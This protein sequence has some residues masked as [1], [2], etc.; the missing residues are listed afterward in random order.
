MTRL[1]P[2]CTPAGRLTAPL[3]LSALA[4]LLLSAAPVD[5][6]DMEVPVGRQVPL[7]TRVLAFDRSLEG[8]GPLVVALVYQERNR[9][10]RAA[11]D[12]FE[13]ALRGQ[14]L[15][16]H[17]RPVRVAPVAVT[18]VSG[19]AG[20]LHQ[21]GADAAYVAPL[22]GLD[23]GA[24]GRAAS[25]A[26]VL[27]LTGVREYVSGGVAVGVGLRGG[28]PEILINRRAA[29]AAGADLSAR[30]LQLATTVDR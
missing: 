15:A 3:V 24:V 12:A 6:V 21:A 2:P 30:L 5:A 8:S 4:V 7:L 19:L 11:R 16:V 22:R 25:G 28:R 1:A 20:R 26:G 27:S 18:S 17:G 14:A 9:E 10:S 29:R 13:A 23:A